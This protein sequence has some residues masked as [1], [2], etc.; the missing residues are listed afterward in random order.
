MCAPRC[1]AANANS[2]KGAIEQR[3]QRFQVYAND[4]AT[5]ADDYKTL[6]VAYRNNAAVRLSDVADVSDGVENVRNL[7]IANGKPAVLVNITKQPGANVIQVV[8]R[9]MS[10]AARAAGRAAARHRSRSSSTDTTTSIRNS[11]ARC[12]DDADP[13]HHPGDAGGVPVPA[14]FRARRWCRR[15]RCRCRCSAPSA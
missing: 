8:D 12:R 10:A 15:L 9:I 11:R 5:Q 3:R 6:I 2:P 7:G 1:R 13:L 4:T 14:Q